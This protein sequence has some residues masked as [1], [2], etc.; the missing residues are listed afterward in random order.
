MIERLLRG[1][2][3]LAAK[4]IVPFVTISVAT[5][6]GLGMLFVTSQGS[7]L[8]QSL[9]RKAEILAR[10]LATAAT[11]PFYRGKFQ[12][13]QQLVEAAR[14]ADADVTYVVLVAMDGRGVAST[15]ETWRDQTLTRSEFESSALRITG[16][17]RRSTPAAGAFELVMPVG[18]EKH[19]LGV[20]R[21][22]VS[23][24][25]VDALALRA[26]WTFVGVGALAL[27]LGMAIYAWVARRVVRPL[28]AAVT[29]LEELASGEADLTLRLETTS[30]DETGQLGR[31]LNTFLDN[32]HQLVAQIAETAVQVRSVAAQLSDAF[33]HLSNAAQEQATALE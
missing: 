15:D 4:L 26:T 31:A 9:E 21:V 22:G 3:S 18:L 33:G 7:A 28:R 29:R 14:R 11:D 2:L 24:A 20:L 25:Q 12:Q 13:L 10:N 16:F 5:T 32:L 6:A 1:H 30:D 27:G 8:S 17:T 23:T 19:Q